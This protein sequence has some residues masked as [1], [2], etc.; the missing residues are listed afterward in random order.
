MEIEEIGS[1]LIEALENANYKESTVFNYKGVLRR[2]KAFCRE[3]EVAEYSSE[4]GAEYANAVISPI[5][6]KYSPQRYFSQMRFIRFLDSFLE[7]GNFVFDT[8]KK[9]QVTPSNISLR[10]EYEKSLSF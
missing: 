5:T 7:T 4:I 2:F 6:G 8:M 3:K 1:K 9:G 10:A